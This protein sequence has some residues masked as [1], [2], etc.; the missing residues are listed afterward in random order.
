[1]L[2][3]CS[4]WWMENWYWGGCCSKLNFCTEEAGNGQWRTLPKFITTSIKARYLKTPQTGYKP[5]R[6]YTCESV[7]TEISFC[8]IPGSGEAKAESVKMK[9]CR[10]KWETWEILEPKP[11]EGWEWSK[12][13]VKRSPEVRHIECPVRGGKQYSKGIWRR[14]QFNNSRRLRCE[15]PNPRM[16]YPIEF[17][18]TIKARTRE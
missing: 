8:K 13:L 5:W 14:R 9:N 6:F 17:E 10:L 16:T 12:R 1:M 7:T 2:A 18:S 4:L 11:K 15:E 3:I